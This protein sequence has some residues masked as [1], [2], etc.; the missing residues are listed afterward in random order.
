MGEGIFDALSQAT[1]SAVQDS[2]NTGLTDS[3]SL[4]NETIRQGLGTGLQEG[5]NDLLNK[6]GVNTSNI[7]ILGPIMQ[8][9]AQSGI[10]A[11]T[12]VF[13][14][15]IDGNLTLNNLG[16]F[17]DYLTNTLLGNDPGNTGSI[18]SNINVLHDFLG[19]TLESTLGNTLTS[20]NFVSPDVLNKLQSTGLFPSSF[21]GNT[22]SPTGGGL[23]DNTSFAMDMFSFHPKYKFLYIVKIIFSEEYS[24]INDSFT[25]LIKHFER[26]KITI[27]HDE[28]NFY[29]F[30]S[31]VPKRTVYQPLT[32]DIHDDIK[33]N[34]MQFF[35]G[36]LRRVS[37]IFNHSNSGLYEKNGMD[38]ANS[39]GSYGLSTQK[40]AKSV[41]KEISIYHVYDYGE[42]MDVHTFFNP[43]VLE[44]TLDELDMSVGDSGNAISVN[45]AYDGLFID[46]GVKANSGKFGN[47]LGISE[48]IASPKAKTLQSGGGTRDSKLT[49][50]LASTDTGGSLPL[51][52][53]TSLMSSLGNIPGVS[54]ALQTAGIPGSVSS[55]EWSS[56]F[57][58]APSS[59]SGISFDSLKQGAALLESTVPMATQAIG[60]TSFDPFSGVNPSELS[61]NILQKVMGS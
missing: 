24:K 40:S 9:M 46:T 36:Y 35:V 43:K 25:F 52:N 48:I 30:R 59:I 1:Q 29:N 6:I 45:F 16:G 31:M 44:F 21:K 38:F 5:A 27:E 34:A 13:Q 18:A 3:I 10:S 32:F 53:Q 58:N 55:S 37:P 49:N 42:T 39:T 4:Y 2:V 7:P 12:Q 47:T 51:G 15:V 50:L 54:T 22:A 14:H 19:G 56:V 17:S 8:N 57:K 26:P 11:A 41:I 23:N 61:S 33:N 60:N 20:T 28:V